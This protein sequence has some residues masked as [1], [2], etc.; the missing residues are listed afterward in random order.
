MQDLDHY[1]YY[2]WKITWS[3]PMGQF[4]TGATLFFDDINDWQIEA[5]DILYIHL[6]DDPSP[7]GTWTQVSS[8]APINLWRKWDNQVG[9][10]NFSG[11]GTEI[12]PPYTDNNGNVPQDVTYTFTSPQITT[13]TNY[14]SNG[15]FG[16]GMDPDCHYYN[17]GI[18]FTINTAPVPEPATMLLLGSGLIGL[19]GYGRKKFLRK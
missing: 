10:D 11:Q 6:L 19:A 8:V 17:K 3:L 12:T 1:Y 14:V 16:F 9:G 13:L 7:N 4:I 15:Y 2:L 18:T 5:N